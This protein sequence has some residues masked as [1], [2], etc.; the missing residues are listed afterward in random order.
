MFRPS[1]LVSLIR[2]RQ[3]E[4]SEGFLSLGSNFLSFSLQSKNI[5]IKIYRTITFP[6][7]LYGCETWS[8]NLREEHR[9]RVFENR[10]LTKIYG[11]KAKYREKEKTT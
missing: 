3:I 2:R 5:D 6:V 4:V 11:H 8:P 1:Y 9:Q 7:V 10:A